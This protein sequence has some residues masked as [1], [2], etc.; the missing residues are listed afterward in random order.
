M[1]GR[2]KPKDFCAIEGVP[3]ARHRTV[4][5]QM[6]LLSKSQSNYPFLRKKKPSSFQERG[7][8]VNQ[9]GMEPTLFSSSHERLP[10]DLT[11]DH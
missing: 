8:E 3:T 1:T 2:K 10:E 9:A 6:L 11:Q 4:P 7:A 5:D